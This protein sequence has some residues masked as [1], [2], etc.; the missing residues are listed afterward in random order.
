MSISVGIVGMPNVGK[1]TLFTLLTK[2]SVDTSNYPFATINPNVGVVAVPDQRLKA[3]A[4]LSKSQKVLPATVEFV[5]I[6]GLVKGAHSG[7]GLGNKFLAN[8]R[9][10]DAIA[11]VVRTFSDPNVH[12]VEGGPNPQRD[13]EIIELELVLADLNTAQKRLEKLQGTART[14]DKASKEALVVV[15]RLNNALKAG[16]AA[17]YLAFTSK[18]LT[19]IYDLNLLTIKPVLFILNCDE[20][21]LNDPPPFDTKGAPLVHIPLKSEVELVSLTPDEAQEFRDSMGLAHSGVDTLIQASYELLDLVTYLTTGESETRA[22]TII[23]G[24]H[25]PQAAA[26]IHTDFEKKFVR[27]EVT[28]WQNLIQ[29]GSWAKVKEQGK[30]RIEGKDYVVVDGDVVEFRISP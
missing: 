23:A 10:V 15:E 11:H 25:A 20:N 26:K 29:A 21:Q 30:L 16:Q 1:S 5:D 2:K 28:N 19:H 4:K 3:L 6:A 7:E 9:E 14:G 13:Y 24:T 8:I 12:H 18:E 22:W 17:R 27:A